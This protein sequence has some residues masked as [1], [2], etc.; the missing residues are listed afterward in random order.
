MFIYFIIVTILIKLKKKNLNVLNKIFK[1]SNIIFIYLFCNSYNNN[2]IKKMFNA[3]FE[4]EFA[5]LIMK[6]L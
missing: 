4:L 3:K 1:K 2:K 6:N 5:L